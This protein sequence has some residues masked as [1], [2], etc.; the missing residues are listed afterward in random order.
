MCSATMCA[1]AAGFTTMA[2]SNQ[3]LMYQVAAVVLCAWLAIFALKTIGFITPDGT[4]MV[5][6]WRNLYILAYSMCSEGTFT[7]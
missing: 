3:Q 2:Q 1:N 4:L 7:V 6:T 5:R